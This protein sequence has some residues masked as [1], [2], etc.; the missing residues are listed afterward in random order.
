M[1]KGIVR[2]PEWSPD[3]RSIHFTVE[4]N[5]PRMLWEVAPD[6]THLHPLFPEWA[7]HAP[8]SG[9]WTPDGKYFA[10]VAGQGD[11]RDLW[12]VRRARRL[13]DTAPRF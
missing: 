10:F 1:V 7:D 2:Y 4:T 13:F 6:S 9:A 11:T 12:A 5:K 3:G 8:R